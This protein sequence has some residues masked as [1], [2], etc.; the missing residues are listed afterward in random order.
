M[1]IVAVGTA[2]FLGSGVT[3]AQDDGAARFADDSA[4]I[5]VVF[6]SY[7]PG[8]AGEA[9]RILREQYAPAGEAAGLT[10][11]VTIH[12][13]TGPYDAAYHWRMENGMSDLEWV[14]SPNNVKFRAALVEQ[15]GSEEAAD[16]VMAAY[17]ATIAR[18]VTSVGHRHI[19]EGED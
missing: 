6:V 14:R 12:F 18:T 4:Y 11:P 1:T 16:A 5:R 8:R 2:L 17:N 9:Y 7:K 15:E 13:Q 3:V 10:G 19:P